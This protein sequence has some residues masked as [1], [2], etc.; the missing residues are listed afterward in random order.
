MKVK[1]LD[2]S[3]LSPHLID[4]AILHDNENGDI[5]VTSTVEVD[6]DP[7][8]IIAYPMDYNSKGAVAA[9]RAKGNEI[10]RE[11]LERVTPTDKIPMLISAAVLS[12]RIFSFYDLERVGGWVVHC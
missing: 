12:S 11:I 10:K 6:T 2:L 4:S 9:V 5:L 1:E 7:W 8:N 3:N